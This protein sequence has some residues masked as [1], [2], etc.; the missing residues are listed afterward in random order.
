MTPDGSK[1]ILVFSGEKGSGKSS[2]A[3]LLKRLTDPTNVDLFGGV[4]EQRQFAVAAANRWV[5][6]F[7]NL[8]HLSTEQ[9]NLLCR[10]ST[11]GGFTYR[12]LYTDLDEVSVKYL[13]PQILT[14]VDLVP[15]RSDILERCLIVRLERIPEK[16]RLSERK[17]ESLI[18]SLLPGIYG[19]LLDLMVVAL[20]NLPTIELDELPR[21]GDFYELC[22]AAGIP[23]FE[24]AY[25]GNI[26]TGNQAAVE[27]N[28]LTDGILALLDAHDGRWQGTATELIQQL[29]ELD[30]TSREFQKLSARSVGK[31]LASSLKGDLTA[32]GVAVDQEKGNR[33]QRSLT[34]RKV[35]QEQRVASQ[36]TQTPTPVLDKE[37]KQSP[38]PMPQNTPARNNGATAVPSAPA[39]PEVSTR[40]EVEEDSHTSRWQWDSLLDAYGRAGVPHWRFRDV[41]SEAAGISKK[42]VGNISLSQEQYRRALNYLANYQNGATA[43]APTNGKAH[44]FSSPPITSTQT[45]LPV[46]PPSN[47]NGHNP[48][49]SHSLDSA[50][51]GLPLAHEGIPPWLWEG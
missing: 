3:S 27:A 2:A 35:S 14:G 44:D 36:P 38:P 8:T 26:E 28:P 33:G 24:S 49:N 4:E 6:C 22:I 13:R 10:A 34:L 17:L 47:S 18:S 48:H 1:P 15:T 12:A 11:G 21:M 42:D 23:N 43:A 40:P 32:V 20:R 16:N 25:A 37:E 29:Q 46:S 39:K 51:I 7:D 41:V 9:Q 19:S 30:P 50:E 31:K 5:L 45:G